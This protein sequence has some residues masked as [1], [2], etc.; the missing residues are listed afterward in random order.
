MASIPAWVAVV[1]AAGAVLGAAI[2]PLAAVYQNTRQ[3]RRERETRHETALREACI[4]LL[5]AA[6][7]LRTMAENNHMYH[8]DEMLVRLS[9]VRERAADASVLW[10][11]I[12]FLAPV[13][14][15]KCAQRLAS[16]A[17]KLSAEAAKNT[18]LDRGVSVRP[19]DLG[20][21]DSCIEDFSTTAAKCF[22]A[23]SRLPAVG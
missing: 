23:R 14:V 6:W 15:G 8:G 4:E 2:A 11:S 9:K 5:R 16:S 7:D 3:A 1:S 21:L 17:D 20:E 10:V 12:A 13:E 19:P 18:D 22:K